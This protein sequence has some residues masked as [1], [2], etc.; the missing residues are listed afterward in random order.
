MQEWLVGQVNQSIYE[1]M[2][3]GEEVS[4]IYCIYSNIFNIRGLKIGF[5]SQGRINIT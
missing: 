3:V 2:F 4:H 1:W 5:F